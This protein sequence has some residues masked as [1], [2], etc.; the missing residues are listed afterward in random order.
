MAV[1]EKKISEYTNIY[2]YLLIRVNAGLQAFILE[3]YAY[4]LIILLI[5]LPPL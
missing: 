2:T 3:V 4:L 1:N 5:T